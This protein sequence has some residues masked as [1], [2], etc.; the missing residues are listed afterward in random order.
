[1]SDQLSMPLSDAC[2]RETVMSPDFHLV[3]QSPVETHVEG[4]LVFIPDF[5][6]SVNYQFDK[7]NE[8][9]EERGF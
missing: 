6:F 9:S 7:C 3:R 2:S 4:F 1:M 5:H 8:S